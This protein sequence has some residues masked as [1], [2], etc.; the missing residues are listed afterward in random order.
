[1]KNK[2]ILLITIPIVV[3]I[4]GIIVFVSLDDIKLNYISYGEFN[5]RLNS[6]DIFSASLDGN[7]L[8]FKIKNESGDYYTDNPESL[9]LKEK[10]LLQNVRLDDSFSNDSSTFI[11][12]LIFYLVFFAFIAFALYKVTS[13]FGGTKFI[14]VKDNKTSFKD[15]CGMENVKEDISK[16]LD[17]IK[18]P[19]K[20]EN[21]GIRAPKGIIL[22]GP[23]GNGKTLFA[24][25][26]A[27]EAGLS[28]IPA[29]GADFQS[30]VM[31][32]GPQ[33]IKAL[34]K[35]ARR[36]SPCIVFIDEFDSIGER[37]S[38][39]G[40]GID[41]ENNRI[42][43]AM[44]NEM[45]G[46]E[47]RSGVLVIGATNSYSSLDAALV[48]PGR[49]DK[50]FNIGNPDKLTIKELIKMYTP[51]VK[52]SKSINLDSLVNCLYGISCS[53]VETLLNEATIEALSCGR[54]EI[55]IDDIIKAGQKTNI[56]KINKL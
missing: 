8:I 19:S 10:L 31:S 41:K 44:L 12:D 22:E 51:T 47:D 25:A 30:A 1:M 3:L 6:G 40:T 11:F 48:R 16:T 38:F 50:K 23:P 37:R 49:F 52:L 4:I 36:H 56:I 33:K 9:E 32:V 24:K 55:I 2:K 42:I 13:I 45:D 21:K 46:F 5:K 18:N 53:S 27:H 26:L 34:F 29:K 35:K 14:I 43:T 54:E 15:I 39:T 28:F 20:Y 17:L 7:K